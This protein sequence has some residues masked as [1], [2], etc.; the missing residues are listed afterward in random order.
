MQSAG[1]LALVG[2]LEVGGGALALWLEL[3]SPWQ[4]L[5]GGVIFSALAGYALHRGYRLVHSGSSTASNR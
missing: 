3:P 1:V 2:M 5:P 4:T